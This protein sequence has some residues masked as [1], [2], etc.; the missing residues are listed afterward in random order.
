M[1]ALNARDSILAAANPA[2]GLAKH[3]TYVHQNCRNPPPQPPAAA[4]GG[5]GD[6][7]DEQ[8]SPPVEP[9]DMRTVRQ[10]VALAKQKNP[11]IPEVLTDLLVESYID[12]RSNSR[13]TSQLSGVD[14]SVFTS[15]RTLLALLR[16]SSALAKIRLSDVVERDD[17]NEALR[18]IAMSKDSLNE[19]LDGMGAGDGEAKAAAD[20]DKIRS[21][22]HSIAKE[23]DSRQVSMSDLIEKS[24]ARGFTIEAVDEAVNESEE[25][26]FISVDRNRTT[27]TIVG[28]RA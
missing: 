2:Y 7:D 12:M 3:I 5:Q 9:L 14:T 8:S 1:T 10:Y 6:E 19:G 20:S 28:Q 25:F 17:V 13:N 4:T 27:I 22:M 11:I 21:I 18:L 26:N 15:A 23:N 24:V 16:L